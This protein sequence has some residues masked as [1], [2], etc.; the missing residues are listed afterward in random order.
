MLESLNQAFISLKANLLRSFLTLLALI[1]GVFSVIVST[2]A[3]AVLDSYFS[4]TLSLMGGDVIQI[5]RSPS[6]QI[7]DGSGSSSIRNRKRLTFDDAETLIEM[8]QI[9]KEITPDETFSFT[10]ISHEGKDTEP[11]IRVVGSNEYYLTSAAYELEDGRNFTP[12]DIQYGRNVAII[13][14]EVRDVLFEFA[15]PLGKTIRVDGRSYSVIGALESKGNVFGQSLDQLI[16]IPFTTGIAAY[17]G[18]RNIDI[19]AKAPN[20]ELIESAIDELT[21]ILRIIRKVAPGDD[22]DFE[23]ETNDSLAGTFDTFTFFFIQSWLWYWNYHSFWSR[24]WGDEYHARFGDGKNP[25]DWNTQISRRY[26]LKH[27]VSIFI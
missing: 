17:G 5:S 6:I 18:N 19:M 9:A 3:V 21:G 24:D 2:T 14:K 12:D 7:D 13:G 1:V 15:D 27:C 10:S 25:R 16:V 8:A 20:M 26:P 11:R 4:S 22:N 23:I